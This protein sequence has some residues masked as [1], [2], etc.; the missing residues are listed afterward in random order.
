[1]THL[2]AL[3]LLVESYRASQN[4]AEATL[5]TRLF[6]DGKRLGAIR[7]GSDVGVR[8][9]DAA[10][11]WFSAN[12]PEGAEWPAAVPRPEPAIKEAAE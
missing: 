2:D 8:R 9:L 1:M 5:S 11:N 3:F 12:W 4:I 6:S 10:I 7:A